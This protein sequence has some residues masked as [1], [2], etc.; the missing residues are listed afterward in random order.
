MNNKKIKSIL[1]N[2][3]DL[4]F[5]KDDEYQSKINNIII[6][7]DDKIPNSKN[8]L[9]CLNNTKLFNPIKNRIEQNIIFSSKFQL[10][11]L[12]DVTHIFIDA[13]FKIAPKNFYQILNILAHNEKTKFTIPV[14]FILITKQIIFILY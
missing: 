7:F 11:F 4:I 2:I 9:F 8:L 3:R 5:P 12:I 6:I 10:K 1:Y 13:N 14:A